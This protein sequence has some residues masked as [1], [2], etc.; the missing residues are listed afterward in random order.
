M[1]RVWQPDDLFAVRR[2]P[3]NNL[4]PESDLVIPAARLRH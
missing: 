4:D 1:T 3:L 2:R